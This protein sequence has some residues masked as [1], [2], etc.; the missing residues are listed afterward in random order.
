[1]NEN[2]ECENF[3]LVSV[4][5]LFLSHMGYMTQKVLKSEVRSEMSVP[6]LC[7]WE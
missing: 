4:Q 6:D 2:I 1:M 5:C 3:T 7:D